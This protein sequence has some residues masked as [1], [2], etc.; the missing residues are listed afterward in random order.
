MGKTYSTDAAHQKRHFVRK[1]KKNYGEG[2]DAS[3][4]NI[5]AS[6]ERSFKVDATRYGNQRRAQASAKVEQRRRDRRAA[7][8]YE[9]D[10]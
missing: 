1:N 5:Y 7:K 6:I 2:S 4:Y 10:E 3:E 9:D 8:N